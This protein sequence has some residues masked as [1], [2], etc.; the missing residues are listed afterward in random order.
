[1]TNA[2]FSQYNPIGFVDVPTV[3]VVFVEDKHLPPQGIGEP[4]VGAVSA[5]I[6]NAVYDAVGI[7]PRDLPFRPEKVLA[8]L[9]A[10]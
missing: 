7:R 10:T 9:K 6:S 8:L 4:A 2:A 3:D 5:A 1:M